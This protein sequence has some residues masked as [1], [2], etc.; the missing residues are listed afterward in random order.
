MAN[1]S[2]DGKLLSTRPTTWNLHLTRRAFL[3]SFERREGRLAGETSQLPHVLLRREVGMVV[4][5]TEPTSE[6]VVA[7]IE[8]LQIHKFSEFLGQLS[9]KKREY[10]NS[11][12]EALRPDAELT[13]DLVVRDV[14]NSQTD[15]VTELL[16]KAAY[17]KNG[18]YQHTTT[19]SDR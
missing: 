18:D 4:L 16:G 11:K 9:C 7:C 17:R 12:Y 1:C 19:R 5:G 14:E 2:L 10:T 8:N 13:L 6:L 15:K 3:R